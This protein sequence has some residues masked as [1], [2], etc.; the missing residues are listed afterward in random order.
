MADEKKVTNAAEPKTALK[1]PCLL[2]LKFS[3]DIET[4]EC[5]KYVSVSTVLNGECLRMKV[6]DSKLVQYIMKSEGYVYT[7]VN[8]VPVS[9]EELANVRDYASSVKAKLG[10]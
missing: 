6:A 9:D 10:V 2:E 1:I 3:K 5:F 7:D 4:G 8:D